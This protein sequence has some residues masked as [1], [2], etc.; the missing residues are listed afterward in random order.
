M[1]SGT[2]YQAWAEDYIRTTSLRDKLT[3]PPNDL[4]WRD[5]PATAP[6]TPGRPRCLTVAD[7]GMPTP[8]VKALAVAHKRAQ[9]IHTFWHHELQAAELMCW[10]LL[11]FPDTPR[12]FR[13][14][15]LAIC[16]DEIRHMQMYGSYL[17]Q[18]GFALGDFPVRDWFWQR[19]PSCSSALSYVA[20]MGIGFEGGNLD[21]TARFARRFRQA[22]DEVGARLQE[23]VGV[24]EVPH[25][26]FALHWYRRWSNRSCFE[27]WRT[28]LPAPLSPLLMRGRPLARAARREAG[29]DDGFIDALAAWKMDMPRMG[30][31]RV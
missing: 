26:R 20:T 23:Q 22:G 1:T 24:E 31:A 17:E 6:A 12:S 13:R 9:L 5:G 27:D 30:T 25:V 16:A 2:S 18:L 15:L 21:H 14:G 29:M 28:H 3:P 19:V 8:G 4:R 11:S 7:V 10:A